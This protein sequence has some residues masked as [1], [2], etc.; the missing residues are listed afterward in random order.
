[1]LINTVYILRDLKINGF[2]FAALIL[3]KI[4]MKKIILT[5]A[6]VFAFGFANAQDKKENSGEGFAKGN[7]F[8]SGAVGFGTESTGD[9]KSNTF[10]FSPRAAYFVTNNI[11]VG[12]ALGLNGTKEEDIVGL[13]STEDK[14][15]KFSVG[16]FGRYYFTPASKFSVFGQLGFNVNNSKIESSSTTGGT[17]VTSETKSN[18]FDIALAPGISYFVSDHFAIEA[19]WGMLKYETTKPD[20][21]A[22]FT[23]ES[24]DSFDFGLN[25]DSINFGLVYK[26]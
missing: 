7:V 15:T 26:F 11:A 5:V 19:S 25:L 21:P 2:I 14:T 20:A 4:N 3:N 8:I 13:T 1:M 12:L 16:A 6:A 17:T 24:T 23:A 18:G 9:Q 10:T 22:G